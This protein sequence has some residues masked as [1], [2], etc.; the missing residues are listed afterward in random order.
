MTLKAGRSPFSDPLHAHR[1]KELPQA[2]WPTAAGVGTYDSMI[3]RRRTGDMRCITSACGSRLR[4]HR[5]YQSNPSAVGPRNT[6]AA[7]MILEN[8]YFLSK[9]GDEGR[10]NPVVRIQT[11]VLSAQ[12][13]SKTDPCALIPTGF[14]HIY[15]QSGP[16]KRCVL[17]DHNQEG[18]AR[19]SS[20]PV[21]EKI[22]DSLRP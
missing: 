17:P 18:Q 3:S 16:I 8:G 15:G 5:E 22:N 4:H 9:I 1:A 20:C 6:A 13:A 19:A 14:L 2:E 10:L 11:S 21:A 12:R 7:R